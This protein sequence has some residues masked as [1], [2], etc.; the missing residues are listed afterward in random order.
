MNNVVRNALAAYRGV[1]ANATRDGMRDAVSFVKQTPYCAKVTER[2]GEVVV[3][4]KPGG[5]TYFVLE[6]VEAWLSKRFQTSLCDIKVLHRTGGR[7][8]Q[9]YVVARIPI[10]KALKDAEAKKSKVRFVVRDEDTRKIFQTWTFPTFEAADAFARRT[11]QEHIGGLLRDPSRR[12]NT[13]NRVENDPGE[14]KRR[15]ALRLYPWYR[16]DGKV[17]DWVEVSE[18]TV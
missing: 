18:E 17:Q 4:T 6:D 11:A 3:E 13:P 9:D 1:A 5:A 16:H 10:P 8:V 15:Y 12:R 7:E 2:N 14:A